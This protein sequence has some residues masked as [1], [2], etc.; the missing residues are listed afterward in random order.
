MSL[1]KRFGI[2]EQALAVAMD[3]VA[4]LPMDYV[5]RGGI[6]E[7]LINAMDDVRSEGECYDA[8]MELLSEEEE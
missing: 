7:E 3:M 4:I 6:L 2:A 8:E 5:R 1:D